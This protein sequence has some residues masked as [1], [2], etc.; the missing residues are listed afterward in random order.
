MKGLLLEV[1]SQDFSDPGGMVIFLSSNLQLSGCGLDRQ[2]L[3][4]NEEMCGLV[5]TIK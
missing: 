1:Y 3:S 2:R 4:L 5:S